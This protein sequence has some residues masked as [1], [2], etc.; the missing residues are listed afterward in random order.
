[1]RHDQNQ[2]ANVKKEADE[3]DANEFKQGLFVCFKFNNMS[4][5]LSE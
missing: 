4:D 5:F 1:V 2:N 3:A